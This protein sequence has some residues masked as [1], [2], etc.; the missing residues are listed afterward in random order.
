MGIG[1]SKSMKSNTK[2]SMNDNNPSDPNAK[3]SKT[4]AFKSNS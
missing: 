4:V 3:K 1:G 2:K